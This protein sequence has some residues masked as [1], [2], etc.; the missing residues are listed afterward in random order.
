M[1]TSQRALGAYRHGLRAARIAFQ[2]DTT[3]LNAARLKMRQGMEKP[4]PELSKDQ[5]ISLMEDVALFLRRNLVQGKKIKESTTT[6]DGKDVYRLNIHKDTELGDNDTVK[7]A[8]TTLKAN[9]GVGCC[10]GSG[11][12]SKS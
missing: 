8:K 3:M 6:S 1:S 5:Q 4:N 7:N 9:G 12:A 11:A 10:G 2:G